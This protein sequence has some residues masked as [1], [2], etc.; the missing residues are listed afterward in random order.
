MYHCLNLT[1]MNN[2][3]PDEF[4]NPPDAEW[5]ALKRSLSGPGAM[6]MAV[7]FNAVAASDE[8]MEIDEYGLPEL[9][10]E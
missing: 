3:A 2:F 8:A 6:L 4:P 10:H 9:V 1:F 7:L 5:S